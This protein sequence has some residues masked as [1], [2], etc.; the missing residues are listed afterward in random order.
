MFFHMSITLISNQSLII[1]A[2]NHSEPNFSFANVS[3]VSVFKV[4]RINIVGDQNL[5][6]YFQ[7]NYSI[8]NDIDIYK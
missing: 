6:E 5:A 4:D 3:T 7:S 2:L 1:I 8:F